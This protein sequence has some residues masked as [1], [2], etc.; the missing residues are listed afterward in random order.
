MIHARKY[1][2]NNREGL[3]A[4]WLAEYPVKPERTDPELLVTFADQ[5][6]LDAY[7]AARQSDYDTEIAKRPVHPEP[8]TLEERL[9][10]LEARVATLEGGGGR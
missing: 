6:E 10:D 5:A 4:D 7:L 9:A 8:P 1:G 2:S 3:P